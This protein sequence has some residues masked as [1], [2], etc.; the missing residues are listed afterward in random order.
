VAKKKSTAKK[1]PAAKK[2]RDPAKVRRATLIGAGVL[3]GAA[4]IA[5]GWV[6]LDRL[7]ARAAEILT[8]AQDEVTIDWPAM[9]PG[10]ATWMPASEQRRLHDLAVGA[11]SG[12]SGLDVAPLR[13]VGRALAQTGWF[14]G[15]PDVRREGD[16]T[17]AIGGTWRV[18]AAV[19]RVGKRERLIAWDGVPLPL[20]YEIGKSGVRYLINPTVATPPAPRTAIEHVPWPGQDVA[21]GL[22]LLDLLDDHPGVIAQVHGIDLTRGGGLEIITDEGTRVVW[23]AAP[24]VFRPGEQGTES[25]LRRLIVLL[26]KTGRIDAGSKRA[27]IQGPNVLVQPRGG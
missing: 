9:E 19:V 18:P 17:L 4:V 25:K 22:A 13:E 2:S 27:E 23:G 10:G 15:P 3:A 1:K 6:G 24:G 14:V 26:E 8:K 21:G 20:E 7:D 5:G 12:G 16:G 11:A